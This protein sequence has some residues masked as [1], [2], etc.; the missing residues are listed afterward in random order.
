LLFP[1]GGTFSAGH[2]EQG[3]AVTRLP[4]ALANPIHQFQ[5]N[6]DADITLLAALRFCFRITLEIHRGPAAWTQ[7]R[8]FA[9]LDVPML[10]RLVEGR[11]DDW[12]GN[13]VAAHSG[14]M[15]T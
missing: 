15:T 5:L 10:P 1:R 7:L 3:I 9:F 2:F 4:G 14:G 13:F 6:G 8:V 11:I 12:L